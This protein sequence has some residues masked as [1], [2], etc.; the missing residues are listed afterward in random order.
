MIMN[1]GYRGMLRP[2]LFRAYGGDAERVHDR[3]LVAIARIGGSRA[4]LTTLAALCARHRSPATVAGI[5]FPGIVG[6][7]AGMDKDGVGIK[8][9]GALGFGFVELGTVTAQPQ[10][11]NGRPHLVSG[12]LRP[13]ADDPISP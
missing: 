4:A 9:W 10:P 11:G 12:E 1:L 2:L 8:T 13:E 7:A 3:T 6:L 5:Q